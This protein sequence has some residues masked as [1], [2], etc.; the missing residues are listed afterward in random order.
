MVEQRHGKRGGV[1]G[2]VNA[3]CSVSKVHRETE[4][5]LAGV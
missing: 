2:L 4:V 5:L 3:V 1:K